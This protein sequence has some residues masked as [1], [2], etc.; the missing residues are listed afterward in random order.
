[1]CLIA[2]PLVVSFF[3]LSS[4]RNTTCTWGEPL[5]T[6]LEVGH[7][8]KS[9]QQTEEEGTQPTIRNPSNESHFVITKKPGFL[10][11]CVD[12][13]IKEGHTYCLLGSNA[14]GKSTLLRLLAKKEEPVEGSIHHAHNVQVAYFGQETMDQLLEDASPSHDRGGVTALSYLASAFPRK[15]EQ[16][17]RAE[18]TNFGLSPAQATTNVRFLSGGERCRLCLAT[19]MLENPQVFCLDN[20]T[21]NLDVESVDA[22]ICG[23]QQWNG[24]VVMAS[25]DTNFIRSLEAECAVL[26]EEEG[27]LRR[28][29]GTVDDYVRVFSH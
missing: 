29:E 19:L 16:E 25:H 21:T 6:A 14:A 4:F 22:L 28:V 3:L 7:A 27:K 17:L 9:T 1:M 2:P 12:V 26:V 23:L 13:C 10:F 20:P 15:T 11:D 18:L 5:I 24:T 8:H